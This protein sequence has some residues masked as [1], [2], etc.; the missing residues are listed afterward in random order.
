MSNY[1]WHTSIEPIPKEDLWLNK[2][3][4]SFYIEDESWEKIVVPKDFK[5]DW[6]SVPRL[7]RI[8]FPKVEPRTIRAACLHDYLFR[9]KYWYC[10]SNIIFLLALKIDWV[11]VIKRYLMFIWVMFWWWYSYYFKKNKN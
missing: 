6:A 3:S 5:F 7:L 9:I 4:F 10:K 8:L 2:N 1:T 11:N